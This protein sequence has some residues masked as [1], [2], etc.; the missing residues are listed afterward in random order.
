MA[1]ERELAELPFLPPETQSAVRRELAKD[2]VAF[3][4]IY[5]DHH[6]RGKE[7]NDQI[8]FS[9]IHFE[10]AELALSWK[11][12]VFEHPMTNRHAF[13]APRAT[14]KS[15]WWFLFLPL[16]AA[17]NGYAQFVAAFAHSAGQAEGHLH[18]LKH[19][20]DTNALLRLDYAELCEPKRKA[21][22]GAI[23]DR[24]SMIHMRNGFVFAA[25]GV[26]AASHGMKVGRSRPD[27]LIFDDVEPGEA[28]YSA[29]QVTKRLGTLTD[30]LFA[31]NTYA[32]VVLVGTVTM[33]GSITHQLVKAAAGTEVASW[34]AEE[35][36]QAHHHRPIAV[37]DDGTE[38]SVWPEKWPLGWLQGRRHTRE[39]A[40]NYDNDPMAREGVYWL[41]EDFGHGVLDAPT[42][43]ILAVDPA[44]T[45]K[46]TSDF[47]GLAVVSYDPTARRCQIEHAVGVRLTGKPLRDHIVQLLG[48]YP[49]IT[50]IV[51]ETNQGGELWQDTLGG[52]PRVRIVPVTSS[53]SKE[54]RFADA[55]RHWQTGRVIHAKPLPLMQEQ[56]VAFPKGAYDD[57]IDAA[58]T[59]VHYFIPPDWQRPAKVGISSAS[60]V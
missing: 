8:T 29:D 32:R 7:T 6:L 54:I 33:P 58:V 44:V 27:L 55:L 31:L 49:H 16:W 23:A 26:D 57:V 5:L 21:H 14:G 42:R 59:G 24:Q 18:T 13:I 34:I 51:V 43:T 48:T 60:Y 28:N 52:L 46:K 3:A 41:R 36:I 17:A 30:D 38:R 37:N 25:R 53:R 15:S 4:L 19:E 22:G 10:W 11:S 50:R 1:L 12:N 9:E 35:R 39:Y 47:T 40:K 45:S 20:L 2:P 56:A